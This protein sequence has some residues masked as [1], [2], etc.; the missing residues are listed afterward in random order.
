MCKLMKLFNSKDWQEPGCKQIL[1]QHS[2]VES[3]HQRILTGKKFEFST[4]T[5]AVR[6]PPQPQSW[7]DHLFYLVHYTALCGLFLLEQGL[8][9]SIVT[10]PEGITYLIIIF[11]WTA[12][13]MFYIVWNAYG[14]NWHHNELPV[15]VAFFVDL[16]GKLHEACGGSYTPL[17]FFVS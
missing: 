1:T 3:T 8:F 12:N 7:Q 5:V 10:S 14:G 16:I 6:L 4:Y 11:A 17:L 15:V 9:V 13:E 2:L